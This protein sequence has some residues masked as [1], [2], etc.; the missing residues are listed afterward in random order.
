MTI[1]G[2]GEPRR[3]DPASGDQA[4]PVHADDGHGTAH[5]GGE[6][7]TA[8][9][10]Q[11][12]A[13]QA[14][15]MRR[16]DRRRGGSGNGVRGLFRFLLFALVLAAI[17][18][19]ALVTILKP[20]ISGAIVDWA[21][22]NPSAL[23]I[24]FVADMV[25]DDLGSALTSAP[26]TDTTQVDFVVADG[27]TAT[28]IADRLHDEGFL[29]DPRAFIF[30]AIR[31]DLT[32][33][34]EAGT[35]ILHRDLTPDQLVTALLQ[36][37]DLAIALPFRE[38]LRLEQVVAK[39]ETLPV[40][41][42]VG[43]FYELVKHPTPAILA[44]HPWL[45]LPKGASL[46]GFLAPGTYS[47]LPDITPEALV[48]KMLDAFYEQVGADR[49]N[50]PKSRGMSFYEIVTLASLVERELI[51]DSERPLIAGVF[52]NRL[53]PKLFPLGEFQSDAT[54][55]YVNDSI[56]LAKKPIAQWTDYVFWAP[57]NG[58]LQGVSI[59]ADLQAYDTYSSKGLMP[60][61][62]STPSVASIDAALN[63]DTKA[64]YLFFLA[65]HDGS[66]TTAFAKT[67]AE[68]EK[69]IKKYGSN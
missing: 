51:L 13:E 37:K 40:T 57:V 7:A 49:M 10:A 27:D 15:A 39:L 6:W 17:V 33:H 28:T 21:A 26:S 48:N 65:K 5:D 55:F 50:V 23:G 4:R 32:S 66:N 35:F 8:A 14:A 60:G 41:M 31:R 45:D 47:V 16:L 20:L 11:P 42:D 29:T 63:P 19:V 2:G 58:K 67:Q 69:N 34:L 68:H 53:N 43:Q 56:Q 36:A 30:T 9:V 61:P 54:V 12:T 1:R 44:A 38:G 24:P 59:P 46:E 64:G 3:R 18:L 62:I 22:E 52:Q 25:R